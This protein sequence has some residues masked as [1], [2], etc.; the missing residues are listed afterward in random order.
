MTRRRPDRSRGPLRSCLTPAG[1]VVA[2]DGVDGAGKT[3]FADALAERLRAAGRDVVRASIDGFHHPLAYRRAEGRTPEAVWR[4]HFDYAALRRELM[5]PWRAG[6]PATYRPA[7][8]DVAFDVAWTCRHG[9]RPRKGCWSWTDCSASVPELAG[10]WDVVVF[11]D[12]PF[13]VSVARMAARDGSADDVERPGPAAVRRRAADLLPHLHP[14]STRG[15]GGRQP[16]T[17]PVRH[18]ARPMDM[19]RLVL[20]LGLL[21]APLMWLGAEPA[22][23]CSCVPSTTADYV[24]RA[25]VIANGRL[26]EREDKGRPWSTRSWAPSG[27]AAAS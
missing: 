16:M 2:V 7:V 3:T 22:L 8:H 17:E 25:D 26:V 21:V 20:L 1:P 19:R 11:L 13:E 15:P 4:R 12:V 24:E 9:P 10:C 14:Q 18:R 5:E 23:A 6:P 27:G